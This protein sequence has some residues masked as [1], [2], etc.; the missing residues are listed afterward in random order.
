MENQ[1][2]SRRDFF[3]L[4]ALGVGALALGASNANAAEKAK[5]MKFNTA[6]ITI[7]KR[8][9]IK[10][11]YLNPARGNKSP[12]AGNLWG[13]FREARATGYILKPKD[14]FKS[15]PHIHN[16]DYKAVIIEGKFH[17]G[18][19][20]EKEMWMGNGGYWTQPKGLVHETFAKDG[21]DRL[22][23]IE[24]E[25]GPYEVLAPKQAFENSDKQVRMDPSNII[26]HNAND[27]KWI[28][29]AASKAGAKVAYFWGS[30]EEGKF[31]GT[32]V[33][34]PARFKGKLAVYGDDFKAVVVRGKPT[35]TLE[36]KKSET[37]EPAS[38]FGAEGGPF[39]QS[40]TSAPSEETILYIRTNGL[41][42]VELA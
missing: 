22:A 36:N 29:E 39:K 4:G 35:L 38:F 28:D 14:G 21:K 10:W 41:Y 34:F 20:G 9:D 31:S 12:G 3:K 15:P 1:K 5:K 11:N 32:F 18:T 24:I 16:V 26:W 37:L 40:V 23:L 42:N 17:N 2:N 6:K 30:P 27:V 8:E 25:E 7:V 19:A 33:K 13:D